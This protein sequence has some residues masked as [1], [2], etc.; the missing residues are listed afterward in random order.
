MYTILS[1]NTSS[2]IYELNLKFYLFKENTLLE[3]IEHQTKLSL[4][5]EDNRSINNKYRKVNTKYLA[6]IGLT[7]RGETA[8]VVSQVSCIN[9]EYFICA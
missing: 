1:I 4:G 6:L 8:D 9:P 7:A 5:T 3:C 2:Q